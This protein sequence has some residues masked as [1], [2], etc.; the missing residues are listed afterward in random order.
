MAGEGSPDGAPVST[1]LSAADARS[2]RSSI[3]RMRLAHLAFLSDVRIRAEQRFRRSSVLVEE[4]PQC[5]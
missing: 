2:T 4:E 3:K 1:S 5:L